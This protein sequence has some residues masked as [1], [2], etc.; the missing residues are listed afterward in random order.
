MQTHFET[1]DDLTEQSENCQNHREQKESL[2]IPERNDNANSRTSAIKLKDSVSNE[3]LDVSVRDKELEVP[4][5]DK[6]ENERNEL[7][8][9]RIED[10]IICKVH[11]LEHTEKVWGK[12]ITEKYVST[13]ERK[14]YIWGKSIVAEYHESR[15]TA[16]AEND[17]SCSGEHKESLRVCQRNKQHI[18]KGN[19]PRK[20]K[21]KRGSCDNSQ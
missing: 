2:K 7:D 8:N 14:G 9:A 18:Q 1:K 17:Y 11:D 20:R 5:K 19:H 3:V 21:L 4:G 10:F 15:K 16:E 13:L 12:R 6:D